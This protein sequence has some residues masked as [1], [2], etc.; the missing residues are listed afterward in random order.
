MFCRFLPGTLRDARGCGCAHHTGCCIPLLR[1]FVAS[2]TKAGAPARLLHTGLTN[3]HGR[4]C[5][6]LV[7]GF[8]S[9]QKLPWCSSLGAFRCR[10]LFRGHGVLYIR[11]SSPHRARQEHRGAGR[12]P[13]WSPR[14]FVAQLPGHQLSNTRH[15]VSRSFRRFPLF[16][17]WRIRVQTFGCTKSDPHTVRFLGVAHAQHV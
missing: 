5:G 3:F 10:M 2:P 15:T 9:W 12:K 11:L 6:F 1:A 8:D 13:A 17:A 16:R 7:V 4:T 14:R